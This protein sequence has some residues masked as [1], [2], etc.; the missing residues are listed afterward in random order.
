[1]LAKRSPG[2]TGHISM[3]RL[4][5]LIIIRRTL[6]KEGFV[7]GS[8][9]RNNGLTGLLCLALPN[10]VLQNAWV[11]TLASSGVYTNANRTL[12]YVSLNRS[13]YVVDISLSLIYHIGYIITSM[14]SSLKSKS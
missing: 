5:L 8:V 4:H 2:R 3:E 7:R 1:M 11:N 10:V 12:Q 6:Q 14:L 13:Q 9:S